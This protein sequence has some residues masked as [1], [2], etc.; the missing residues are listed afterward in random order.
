V[1]AADDGFGD[2][3]VDRPAGGGGGVDHGGAR[4]ERR[5]RQADGDDLRPG[6]EPEGVRA[7]H[8][9]TVGPEVPGADG[10]EPQDE[11]R[12]HREPEQQA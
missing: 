10:A 9:G 1:R 2:G 7:D 8:P 3:E 4:A 6:A 11:T 12:D 5:L